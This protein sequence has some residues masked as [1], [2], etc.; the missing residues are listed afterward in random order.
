MR[1]FGGRLLVDSL[2]FA[3][4]FIST[5]YIFLMR[6]GIYLFNIRRKNDALENVSPFKSAY[7]G[8]VEFQE[9]NIF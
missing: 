3:N 4:G 6:L 8:Y 2:A 5:I 1:F 9:G 7:L